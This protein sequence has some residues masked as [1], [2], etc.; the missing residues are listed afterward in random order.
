MT[1]SMYWP[2]VIGAVG[3]VISVGMACN[4]ALT[5]IDS[6][7]HGG[8]THE[9]VGGDAGVKT[10]CPRGNKA[11]TVTWAQTYAPDDTGWY[12]FL[13]SLDSLDNITVGGGEMSGRGWV[14]RFDE[15]HRI[16]WQDLV[17]GVPARCETAQL[18]DGGIFAA[19]E[20]TVECPPG[21]AIQD[22]DTDVLLRSYGKD[23]ELQWSD[24]LTAKDLKGNDRP[25]NAVVLDD[26][27]VGLAYNLSVAGVDASRASWRVYDSDGSVELDEPLVLSNGQNVTTVWHIAKVPGSRKLVATGSVDGFTSV[28]FGMSEVGQVD[29]EHFG[30]TD[31]RGFGGRV[32]PLGDGVAASGYERDDEGS[33]GVLEVF[34]ARGNSVRRTVF[35]SEQGS[36][37]ALGGVA[38]TGDERIFVAVNDQDPS[39]KGI[40]YVAEV[41]SQGKVLWRSPS[42]GEISAAASGLTLR[43]ETCSLLLFGSMWEQLDGGLVT[44]ALAVELSL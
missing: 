14:V 8:R 18:A 42:F 11:G 24:S 30:T 26:A 35:P 20:G 37:S 39:G 44:S 23:G 33:F 41:S 1:V 31:G 38:T 25:S 28:V 17:G 43:K 32:A 6:S 9:G 3:S 36:W 21:S 40:T 7:A 19:C 12:G 2:L 16:V 34:D 27:R 13:H 15:Q 29:W 22:C 10:S 5:P 4:S